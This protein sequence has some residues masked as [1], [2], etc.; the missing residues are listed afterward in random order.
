MSQLLISFIVQNFLPSPQEYLFGSGYYVYLL[1][2]MIIN[3]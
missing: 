1:D 2:E 3:R